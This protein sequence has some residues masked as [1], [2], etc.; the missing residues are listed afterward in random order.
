MKKIISFSSIGIILLAM[1]VPSVAQVPGKIMYRGYLKVDEVVPPG[2]VQ[3]TLVFN[4]YDQETS[5]TLIESV[6]KEFVDI[7]DGNF[8]VT[9]DFAPNNFIGG[10]RYL[11]VVVG[12]EELTPRQQFVTVPYA[13]QA[14]NLT[15]TSDGKVGIGT[16][17]PSSTLTVA[18]TVESTGL[19]VNG[20]IQSNGVT[21]NGLVHA[22]SGGFK[23]PDATTQTTA[24]VPA[25]ANA[26]HAED[27]DPPNVVW[28]DAEGDVGIGTTAA[29]AK[30]HVVGSTRITESLRVGTTQAVDTPLTVV[31]YSG[32]I[33]TGGSPS[34]NWAAEVEN[35]STNADENCLAVTTFRGT[36]DSVPFLVGY[37][38]RVALEPRYRDLFRVSGDGNAWLVGSLTEGSD[39]RY[40]ENIEPISDSLE[41]ILQLNGVSYDRRRE[42]ASPPGEL[43]ERQLGL[44][45]QEVELVLPEAVQKDSEGYYSVAYTRIVPVLIEAIKEQ[46]KVIEAQETRLEQLSERL[47]ELE[48]TIEKAD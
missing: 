42:E 35:R 30:L 28:V 40:K 3:E 21:S 41:T 27:G 37:S 32:A 43:E 38:Y 8:S 11:G 4:L 2:Q 22:T 24:F 31:R 47:A 39:I 5:G 17:T 1:S 14:G 12:G 9:L 18:G 16:T 36:A 23:F 6:T 7:F 45:G 48:N 13:Y 29:E 25:P 26:L 15:S 10:N 46:Q 19:T 44:I 34:G 33:G 20:S